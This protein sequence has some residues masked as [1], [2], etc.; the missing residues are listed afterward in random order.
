MN[1]APDAL[2]GAAAADVSRHRFV[3]VFIGGPW[4]FAQQHG[5]AHQLSRLAIAALRHVF[6]NPSAL[7]RM[8]QIVREAPMVVTSL[9]AARDSGATQDRTASPSRCTV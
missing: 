9:P 5:S 8:T 7:Q 4:F 2:I 3:D 1:G 6:G